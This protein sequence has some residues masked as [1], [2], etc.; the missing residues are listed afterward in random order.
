[1]LLVFNEGHH[2]FILTFQ[3][4]FFKF[5]LKDFILRSV[6]VVRF[7]VDQTGRSSHSYWVQ[8]DFL[9]RLL[10]FE[11]FR[12][13]LAATCFS[14]PNVPKHKMKPIANNGFFLSCHF[15]AS[16]LLASFNHRRDPDCRPVPFDLSS[17]AE[18]L[19]VY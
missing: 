7:I 1:M 9:D 10:N 17:V 15:R 18:S 3:V 8:H 2:L 5:T 6:A 11:E 12:T 19:K 16:I 4:A 13:Y 14:K